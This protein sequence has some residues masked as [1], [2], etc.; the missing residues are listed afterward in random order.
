M[1]V[2]S[3]TCEYVCIQM[4]VITCVFIVCSFFIMSEK[5]LTATTLGLPVISM[6]VHDNSLLLSDSGLSASQQHDAQL[7]LTLQSMHANSYWLLLALS[8]VFILQPSRMLLCLYDCLCCV[9][10]L[11]QYKLRQQ[12]KAVASPH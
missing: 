11:L 3:A 5:G 9:R 7:L 2:H 12:S 1:R 8:L 10:L 4:C 6:T